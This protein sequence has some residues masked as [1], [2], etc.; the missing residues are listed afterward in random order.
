MIL[1]KHKQQQAQ[2]PRQPQQVQQPNTSSSVLN[3]ADR[4]R[5]LEQTNKTMVSELRDIIG[6]LRMRGYN[7]SRLNVIYTR[8][9]S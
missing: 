4:I 5:E 1:N 7:C 8:L 2:Q 9:L 6:E 3:M